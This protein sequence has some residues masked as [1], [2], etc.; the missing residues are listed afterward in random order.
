MSLSSKRITLVFSQ[1]QHFSIHSNLRHKAK[2]FI[3]NKENKLDYNTHLYDPEI[4]AY[5][6][7]RWTKKSEIGIKILYIVNA[8]YNFRVKNLHHKTF[9][10]Y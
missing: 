8:I 3:E 7:R 4:Q 9:K 5:L 2:Y 6:E 10:K 1:F